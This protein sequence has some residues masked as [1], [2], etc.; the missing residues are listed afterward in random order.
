MTKNLRRSAS[1]ARVA[2]GSRTLPA[3]GIAQPLLF[4]NNFLVVVEP[5]GIL[6]TRTEFA[7]AVTINGNI[8]AA[9]P[10]LSIRC[11]K[12]GMKTTRVNDPK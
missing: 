9:Y 8:P 3:A 6:S 12:I 10:V 5:S 4:L 1:V 2:N 7:P 11:T